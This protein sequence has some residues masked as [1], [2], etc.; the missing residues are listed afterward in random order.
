MLPLN[1]SRSSLPTTYYLLPTILLLA[2]CSH[3]PSRKASDS[4]TVRDL[5]QTSEEVRPLAC[6][7]DQTGQLRVIYAAREKMFHVAAPEGFSAGG[8]PETLPFS[9]PPS[10]TPASLIFDAQNR[11]HF[12]YQGKNGLHYAIRQNEGWILALLTDHLRNGASWQTFFDSQ[13]VPTI[14]FEHRENFLAVTKPT[15]AGWRELRLPLSDKN[16][17]GR[18][19]CSTAK[20]DAEH[21]RLHFAAIRE[22]NKKAHLWYAAANITNY[23]QRTVSAPTGI[24]EM[25]STDG[26]WEETFSLFEFKVNSIGGCTVNLGNDLPGSIHFTWV[27]WAKKQWTGKEH[28]RFGRY[29]K[30]WKIKTLEKNIASGNRGLVFARDSNGTDQFDLVVF[31]PTTQVLRYLAL[32]EEGAMREKGTIPFLSGAPPCLALKK[33]TPQVGRGKKDVGN[34]KPGG[35]AWIVVSQKEGLKAFVENARP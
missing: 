33:G 18:I 2:S 13:N 26:V 23:P 29:D 25:L 28:L 30:E 9:A 7:F 16:E 19:V 3:L 5:V 20:L 17:P 15:T 32:D 35:G 21:K 14:I 1:P 4:W 8:L 10:R 31:N 34:S 24:Q 22:K 12:F 11:A 6:A 27:D